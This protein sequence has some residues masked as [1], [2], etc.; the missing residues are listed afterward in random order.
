M[1][2]AWFVIDGPKVL[3]VL[4]IAVGVFD[5]DIVGKDRDRR[6]EDH[7]TKADDS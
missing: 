6:Y 5:S 7:H 1:C 4:E 3:S 2:S